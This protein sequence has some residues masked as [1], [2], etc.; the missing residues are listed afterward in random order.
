MPTLAVIKTVTTVANIVLPIVICL[1]IAL[2]F[3]IAY[4]KIFKESFDNENLNTVQNLANQ[5]NEIKLTENET[6]NPVTNTAGNQLDI[7]SNEIR[8][9]VKASAEEQNEGQSINWDNATTGEQ[10][11]YNEIV[12]NEEKKNSAKYL[13][14]MAARNAAKQGTLYFENI[15]QTKNIRP[16]KPLNL[17]VDNKETFNGGGGQYTDNTVYSNDYFNNTLGNIIT[18]YRPPEGEYYS[19]L[20]ANTEKS[21]DLAKIDNLIS[22][23]TTQTVINKYTN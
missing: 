6:E 22:E 1:L 12:H 3:F 20:V 18:T 13:D 21:D 8:T 5:S 2:I 11:N 15:N 7:D 10:T 17:D 16:Y 4:N 9:I 23:A 14:D 19:S